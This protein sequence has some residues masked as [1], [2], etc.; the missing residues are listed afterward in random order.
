MG[1]MR[2]SSKLGQADIIFYYI[3]KK[4]QISNMQKGQIVRV[5]YS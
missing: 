3:Q 1:K 5:N 2:S 4:H